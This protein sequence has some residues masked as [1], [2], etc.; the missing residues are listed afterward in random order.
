L[1]LI[2]SESSADKTAAASWAGVMSK[3]LKEILKEISVLY[4]LKYSVHLLSDVVNISAVCL[5]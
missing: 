1:N 2:S 4:V 3:T 5:L